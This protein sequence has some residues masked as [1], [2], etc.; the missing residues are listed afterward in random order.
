MSACTDVITS[1]RPA[2]VVESSTTSVPSGVDALTVPSGAT[3]KVICATSGLAGVILVIPLC[4][5][6]RRDGSRDGRTSQCVAALPLLR[7][8]QPEREQARDR[9]TERLTGHELA[10]LPLGHRVARRLQ[11]LQQV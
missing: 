7:L 10:Q 1:G 5:T 6:D 3:P 4:Y 11:Q 9:T 2:A 8:D